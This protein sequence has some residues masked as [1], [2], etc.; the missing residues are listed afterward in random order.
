MIE[1]SLD[2]ETKGRLAALAP[3]GLTYFSLGAG[4]VRGALLH[5]TAMVNRMRANHRLGPLETLVLGKAYLGAALVGSTLKGGDR[6]VLRVDGDGPA[7]GC[8]VEASAE[9]AVRGWLFRSPIDGSALPGEGE[10]FSPFG[11]GSLTLSR[12]SE[13]RSTPFIGTVALRTGSLAEDLSAYYLESE[14]TRTA[15]VLGLDFDR[16]GAAT[17][18][19]GL[20]VQALPGTDE[21][22][23]EAVEETVRSLPPIAR[24][25]SSGGDREDYLYKSLRPHFPEILGERKA[26]FECPCSRERFASYI[27][28]ANGEL[29]AEL[30][31]TGPWPVETVCHN[32]GSAYHFQKGELDAML[33]RRERP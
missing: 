8:S 3:D 30:A 16:S 15:F 18:A 14:Q 10:A 12:F 29:L 4:K 24:H 9:V 19:G 7:E 6:A 28:G 13:G 5:G 31:E 32:C 33:A 23:L 1:A 20:F 11:S 22:F 2:S 25:F 26:A 27:D 21:A 17:G